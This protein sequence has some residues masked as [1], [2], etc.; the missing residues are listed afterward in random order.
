[1]S[2]NLFV[3]FISPTITILLA[4]V[5]EMKLFFELNSHSIKSVI[6]PKNSEINRFSNLVLL[7]IIFCFVALFVS[8]V[9][10]NPIFFVPISLVINVVIAYYIN[11]KNIVFIYFQETKLLIWTFSAFESYFSEIE[12]D[13]I[14]VFVITRPDTVTKLFGKNGEKE[15]AFVNL[16][17]QGEQK[18]LEINLE[19]YESNAIKSYFSDRGKPVYSK[20]NYEKTAKRI[21]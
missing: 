9:F 4:L 17:L 5:L 15:R 11:Y 13:A 20:I 10:K 19:Y 14:E 18:S 8:L 12:L 7:F 16:I 2:D 1:M 3:Y 21:N 6:Y